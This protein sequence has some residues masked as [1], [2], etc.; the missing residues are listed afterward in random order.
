MSIICK[1]NDLR[2]LCDANLGGSIRLE[3]E[4]TDCVCLVKRRYALSLS[5]S[6]VCCENI[7]RISTRLLVI[8]SLHAA[9][10]NALCTGE[11][12]ILISRIFMFTRYKDKDYVYVILHERGNNLV[13]ITKAQRWSFASGATS[14][15]DTPTRGAVLTLHH[16]FHY[17]A[18]Q[19]PSQNFSP[20]VN[21]TR[22]FLAR[23]V[24]TRADVNRSIR[25]RSRGREP[26]TC[27][28]DF[29]FIC[30][31]GESGRERPKE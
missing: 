17:I 14:S 11:L 27:L 13:S 7:S 21:T 8:N 10:L 9:D 24:S 25:I 16:R 29:A 31:V 18:L 1:S 15:G 19:P 5:T 22:I 3:N 28:E 26:T 30:I 23:R 12:Y 2:V 20:V 4:I 6:T